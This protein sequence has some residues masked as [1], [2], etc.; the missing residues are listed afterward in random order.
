M[1]ALHY[2]HHRTRGKRGRRREILRCCTLTVNRG[3]LR[4]KDRKNVKEELWA[5][6]TVAPFTFR[7]G[8]ARRWGGGVFLRAQDRDK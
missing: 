5:Q 4:E 2:L 8:R 6:F 7:S 1:F 3:H